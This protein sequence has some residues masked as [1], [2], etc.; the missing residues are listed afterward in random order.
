[1]KFSIVA[2]ASLLATLSGTAMAA[3]AG[4]EGGMAGKLEARGVPFTG[5]E[6]CKNGNG[7]WCYSE[8][9]DATHTGYSIQFSCDWGDRYD[10][11]NEG[12]GVFKVGGDG[13]RLGTCQKDGNRYKCW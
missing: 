5:L 9:R 10:I 12:G 4:A 13:R 11:W 8:C 2:L 3:P 7:V 1:M 6:T